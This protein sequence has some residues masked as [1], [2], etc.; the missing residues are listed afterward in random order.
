MSLRTRVALLTALATAVAVVLVSFAAWVSANRAMRDTVDAQLR[1]RAE[2]FNSSGG[3][4]PAPFL[5]GDVSVQFINDRGGVVQ[6]GELE[7]EVTEADIEVARTGT[8][9]VWRDEV[10]STA[11]GDSLKVRVLTVPTRLPDERLSGAVLLARPLREIEGSLERLRGALVVLSAAGV[12]VAGLAGG[13]IGHRAV[14]PVSKLTDAAEQVSRTRQLDTRIELDRGDELGRL[15]HSFN[16]MLAALEQSRDQQ[17]RLIYDASH[18]LRTPLTS[19]RTNVELLKRAE[20]VPAEQRAPILDDVLFELD[21]LT[22]LVSELVALATDQHQEG[23][24][25]TVDLADITSLVVERHRRRSSM[26]IEL[27][28]TSTL[29]SGVPALIERAVSNL[30]DNAIKFSPVGGTVWVKVADGAV[31]VSDE[32]PGIAPQDRDAVFERFWRAPEARTLPG[33]GLGLSIVS[34]VAESH[35][36]HV[37]VVDGPTPGATLRFDLPPAED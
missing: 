11:E 3:R 14:R 37:A 13:L 16:T 31:E 21:E 27:D 2:G 9:R 18:E 6:F 12:A 1:E 15:A 35:G 5:A 7:V 30:V 22:A 10:A 29:V 36:G 33:S 26:T 8:G 20:S 4:R 34:Q 28:A 32:G 25:E 19:L 23:A 24:V 17:E